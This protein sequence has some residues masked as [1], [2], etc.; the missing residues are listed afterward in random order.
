MGKLVDK[1][2]EVTQASSRGMGFLG[3][4][5][6]PE[7]AARPAA[8]LVSGGKGDVATLTAAVENG[9]DG[10]L[11]SGW[12][13]GSDGFAGLIETVGKRGAVWGIELEGEI[14]A[15]A[16]AAAHGKGAGFAVLGQT[17]PASA[18][19]EEIERFDRVIT[20]DPPR[21]DLALLSLRAVNLLPAQAALVQ[22]QFAP[23]ALTRLTIADFTR[24]R[25]LWES[26]R[27]P[28]LVTLRGGFPS[29]SDLRLLVQLGADALVV[30]GAG[31]AAPAFG[32]HVK[33]LV[34]ELERTPARREPD[35][36]GSLLGGLVGSAGEAPAAPAPEPGRR[37][38]P[39]P[40]EE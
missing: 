38:A 4:A 34:G 16:L 24:L 25:L 12:S 29:T 36:A 40:D 32:E 20:I 19:F 11:L 17:A 14:G 39:E 2:R 35:E 33:A 37:P 13:A 18:L 7:R 1:L 21:D 5:R 23:G 26:L 30:D 15:D 3:R 8:L 10:V 27:F 6:G 31:A 9:A 28:S 22:A